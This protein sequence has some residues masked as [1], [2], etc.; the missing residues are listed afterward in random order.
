LPRLALNLDLPDLSLSSNEDYRHKLPAHSVHLSFCN[1]H[2]LLSITSEFV[3]VVACGRIS[4]LR[5]NNIPL[6]VCV[7]AYT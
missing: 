1:Q 7:C 5:L 4:F 2:V 6:C 3:H